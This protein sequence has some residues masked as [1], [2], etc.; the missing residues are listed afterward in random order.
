MGDW[1]SKVG[2][3]L[4]SELVNNCIVLNW[5]R[6]WHGSNILQHFISTI[7][8]E[9]PAIINVFGHSVFISNNEA[10]RVFSMQIRWCQVN[11][12]GVLNHLEKFL[13]DVIFFP[14]KKNFIRKLNKILDNFTTY[15]NLNPTNPK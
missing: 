2:Q 8:D 3:S 4:L 5:N 13:I 14:A 10:N 12:S 7:F 6:F 9:L 1:N 15:F 11:L